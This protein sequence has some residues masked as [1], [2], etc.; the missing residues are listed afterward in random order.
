MKQKISGILDAMAKGLFASLI[1]GVVFTEMGKLFN[2]QLFIDAG[3]YAKVLMGPAI[4]VSIAHHLQYKKM[5]ISTAT[6]IGA[7]SAGSIAGGQIGIGDPLLSLLGSLITLYLC[8]KLEANRVLDIFLIPVFGII[9]SF[10]VY[11]LLSPINIYVLELSKFINDSIIDYPI[12]S[13]FFISLIFAFAISGPFSSAVLAI[14][15]QISGPAAFVA[16]TA[17]TAQ[18]VGFF[19]MG[20]QDNSFVNNLLVLFG[21][22][23]LH[24]KNITLNKYVLFPPL[25]AS[26]ASGILATVFTNITSVK[27]GAGMGSCM[28]VG[29]L[30]TYQANIDNPNILIILLIFNFL[31]PLVITYIVYLIFK[32]ANLIKKGD[33]RL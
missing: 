4:A 17:T 26:I 31:I 16:V 30:L 25:V 20:M 12:M 32:Q 24:L 7:I 18:M 11:N 27:E 2:F 28:L 8:N 29:Q 10:V 15:L 3:F 33:L 9:V 5:T 21:S 14:I 19:I 22:S 23:K 6:I 13:A 1:I